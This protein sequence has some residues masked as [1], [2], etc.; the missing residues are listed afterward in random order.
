MNVKDL[1]NNIDIDAVVLPKHYTTGITGGAEVDM[2]G[3]HAAEFE[4]MVGAPLDTLGASVKITVLLTHADDNG[5]GAA[6]AYSNVTTADVLGVTVAAGIIATI[7]ADSEAS[8]AYRF[9][10]VGGKRFV[11]ALITAVGTHTNGTMV[12]LSIIKGAPEYAPVAV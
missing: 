10:Y 8:R 12:S 9:G 3:F 5:A 4:L 11:T 2:Q 6:G 1:H 7:D